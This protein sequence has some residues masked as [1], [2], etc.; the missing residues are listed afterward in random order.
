MKLQ[1]AVK[2]ETFHITW[3]VCGLGAVMLLVFVLLGRFH[4]PVLSG[5]LAGGAISIIN[6]LLLGIT[7]QKAAQ[8]TSAKGAYL[9]RLSY[10]I[11]ILLLGVY[12]FIAMRATWLN[13]VT[14][15]VSLFFPR[16]TIMIMNFAGYIGKRGGENES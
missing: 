13:S 5:F 2:K 7:V 14:A 15:I 1:P 8:S 4:L 9:I 3:G 12:I 6:F 16:I 11:R 10:S